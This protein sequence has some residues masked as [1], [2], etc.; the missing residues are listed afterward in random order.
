M[1]SVSALDPHK[2]GF[3]D[4]NP[5]TKR[6]SGSGV[7]SFYTN[8]RFFSCFSKI[9]GFRF[10]LYSQKQGRIYWKIPPPP[11]GMVDVIRGE[12]MKRGK[13]KKSRILGNRKK[14]KRERG[15]SKLK[16]VK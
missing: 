7:F 8:L 2:I 4:P 10:P 1:G 11:V 5:N 15:K 6:I 13:I 12:N 14:D 3:L 16:S 9:K